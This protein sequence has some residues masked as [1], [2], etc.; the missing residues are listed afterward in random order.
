MNPIVAIAA[1][2]YLFTVAVSDFRSRKISNRHNIGAALVAFILQFIT[3]GIGGVSAAALGFAAGFLILL[4]PFAC[5]LLG[6]G[7]VKFSAAAGAFLGWRILL[8]GLAGGIILGGVVAMV[9]LISQRQMSTAMKR[10]WGDLYSI[11]AGVRPTALQQA[12]S[13]KTIPYGVMLAI[14]IA[15]AM[16][17]HTWRLI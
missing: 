16:A 15:G 9:S 17:A 10:L 11:A 1:G 4:L 12:A 7:D 3:S 6:G 8:I 13:V 14:G 2:L 5:G